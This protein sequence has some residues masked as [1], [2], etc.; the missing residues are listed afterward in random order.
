MPA[1]LLGHSEFRFED[2]PRRV[3]IQYSPFLWGITMS[4]TD[5]TRRLHVRL[6]LAD[7]V[8]AI[9]FGRLAEH[10]S[11]D[12]EAVFDAG[13]SGVRGVEGIG[14]KTAKAIFDVTDDDVEAELAAA[15][16][17][18]AKVICHGDPEYPIALKHIVDPPAVLYV[19]GELVAADAA[20][21]AVVGS[22]RCTHYGVEQAERFGGLLGRAGLTVVSGGARGIDTASHRGS[23]AA[24]GRTIA[25]MGCGLNH[26]YPHENADLFAQIA[27]QGCGAIVSALPMAVGVQAKNFPARNRIISG[28]SQGV[29][30]IEAARRSGSL[31]TARLAGEQGRQVYALP[32]RVDSLYSQ[33]AH[34]LIRDG[35]VLVQNLDDILEHL[36]ELGDVVAETAPAET[37]PAPIIV[38]DDA[39]QMI[40]DS[41]QGEPMTVDQIA[42]LTG[43]PAHQIIAAMTTLTIKGAVRQLPGGVFALTKAAK[44]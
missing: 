8:G 7:G 10:F 4:D 36:D 35:A 25:V 2:P 32:G 30:V 23:L 31:I 39:E 17:Q 37:V 44:R 14:P 6:H 1:L 34:E 9:T 26:I 43:R 5:T 19:R 20:A 33:G 28:L 27:D 15:A 42:D 24:G 38:L 18:G 13:V 11:G 40:V 29:L 21:M 12:L 22:R 16:E 3:G 41:Y